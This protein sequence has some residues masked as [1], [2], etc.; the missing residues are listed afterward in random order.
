MTIKEDLLL[1]NSRNRMI[2]KMVQIN[3]QLL[4]YCK[5]KQTNIKKKRKQWEWIIQMTA[6]SITVRSWSSSSNGEEDGFVW[7]DPWIKNTVP[8]INPERLAK[9]STKL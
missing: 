6:Y 8:L 2:Y 5:Y 4:W 1:L 3:T 7:A 9:A